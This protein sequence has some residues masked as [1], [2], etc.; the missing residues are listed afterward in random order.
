MG[1]WRIQWKIIALSFF[2]LTQIY[3][4]NSKP[5]EKWATAGY[6]SPKMALQ[7]RPEGLGWDQPRPA[8]GEL[9]HCLDLFATCE[10]SSGSKFNRTGFLR[11]KAGAATGR[12]HSGQA[13]CCWLQSLWSQS[14]DVPLWKCVSFRQVSSLSECQ[15]RVVVRIND[16]I[17]L[18]CS[19]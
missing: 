19:G 6:F 11:P 5:A 4:G 16:L 18:K 2:T 17:W 7:V 13:L 14:L 10:H 12:A 3:H 9:P 8:P 15:Y 1:D